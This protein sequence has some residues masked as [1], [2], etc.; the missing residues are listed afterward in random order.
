[1]K[2]HKGTDFTYGHNQPTYADLKKK[3]QRLEKE[4]PMPKT[5]SESDMDLMKAELKKLQD[6]LNQAQESKTAPRQNGFNGERLP[7]LSPDNLPDNAICTAK[8][9]RNFR[10]SKDRGFGDTINFD[11]NINGKEYSW[12]RKPNNSNLWLLI[13]K[14]VSG[15]RVD[16]EKAGFTNKAGEHLHYI[17][18]VGE[19]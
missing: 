16:L 3:L 18:V 6:K 17:K 13:N 19:E 8:N 9:I 1:M 11:L 2:V 14:V 10:F 15:Q 5:Y 7:F 12:G 4:Q